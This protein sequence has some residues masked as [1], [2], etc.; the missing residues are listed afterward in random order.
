LF[1]FFFFFSFFFFFF[2][3]VF[4]FFFFFFFFFI[5]FFFPFSRASSSPLVIPPLIGALRLPCSFSALCFFQDA[6]CY[7]PHRLPPRFFLPYLLL[8]VLPILNFML[9]YGQYCGLPVLMLSPRLCPNDSLT[10]PVLSFSCVRVDDE[11]FKGHSPLSPTTLLLFFGKGRSFM[12]DPLLFR[13]RNPLTTS[14]FPPHGLECW[15][16]CSMPFSSRSAGGD[17]SGTIGP[18]HC[19]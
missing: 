4:N 8:D 2:F 6:I 16:P 11:V 5:L 13:L 1:F 10:R 19:P 12:I 14:S 7:F 18:H 3:F 9:G 15:A 17:L